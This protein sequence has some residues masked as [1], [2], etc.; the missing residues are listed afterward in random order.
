M[1]KS[2]NDNNDVTT[3]TDNPVYFPQA[4]VISEPEVHQ[5]YCGNGRVKKPLSPGLVETP[6][7]LCSEC[8][9]IMPYYDRHIHVDCDD[10][11]GKGY[12]TIP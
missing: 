3:N 5:C 9:E 11:G 7:E 4:D 8:G 2:V 12:Y 6:D 1:D 10:C